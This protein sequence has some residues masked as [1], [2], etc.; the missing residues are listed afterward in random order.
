M[1]FSVILGLIRL[2]ASDTARLP[3][4]TTCL[5]ATSCEVL[6]FIL[7]VDIKMDIRSPDFN[8]HY[9]IGVLLHDLFCAEV[10]ACLKDI[11]KETTSY[12]DWIPSFSI[13]GRNTDCLL[14]TSDAADE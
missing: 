8:F 7:C 13:V 6:V 3:S 12:K 4:F 1:L 10:A 11:R 5:N 9:F 2:F 14:Y